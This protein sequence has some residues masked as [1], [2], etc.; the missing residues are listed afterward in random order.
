MN[1]DRANDLASA[2]V[3][4]LVNGKPLQVEF[5]L[6]AGL[7]ATFSSPKTV[8]QL[9]GR[10]GFVEVDRAHGCEVSGWTGLTTAY[11]GS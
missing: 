4:T 1:G 11:G 7:R 9:E 2:P 10:Q 8:L 3:E 5:R 6:F